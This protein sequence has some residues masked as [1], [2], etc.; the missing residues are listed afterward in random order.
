M[1][2]SNCV[3]WGLETYL[4]SCLLVCMC[5]GL[6]HRYSDK[7]TGYHDQVTCYHDKVMGYQYKVAGTRSGVS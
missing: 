5:G 6:G 7:V 3:V 2:H 4:Q 1:V